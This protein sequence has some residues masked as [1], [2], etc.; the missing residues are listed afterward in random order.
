MGDP[1]LTVFAPASVLLP[2]IQQA[3]RVE[4]SSL[5]QADVLPSARYD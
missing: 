4:L 5:S 1:D 2:F 3:A